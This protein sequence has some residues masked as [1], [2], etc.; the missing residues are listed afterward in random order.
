MAEEKKEEKT[1]AP[2][3]ENKDKTETVKA[4]PVTL[5]KLNELLTNNLK[6]SQI[7]YE[8]NRKINRKLFW[9]SFFDYLKMA[10]ILVP[11]II[12]FVY[13]LPSINNLMNTVGSLYG[14]TNP[15]NGSTEQSASIDA[16]LNQFP[17]DQA[18]KEQIKALLR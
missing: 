2:E 18:K 14:I 5:E 15:K 16:L 17:L 11:L 13:L 12:G 9:A 1:A 3:T 8:Q 4:E 7:I 10:I 6:W